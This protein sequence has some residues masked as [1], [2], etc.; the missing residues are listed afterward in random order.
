VIDGNAIDLA[1]IKAREQMS[2][3]C[4]VRPQFE[5][6]LPYQSRG[7]QRVIGIITVQKK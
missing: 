7:G 3:F 6:T 2:G 1:Q 5:E 4:M